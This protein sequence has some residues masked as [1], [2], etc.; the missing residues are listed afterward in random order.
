[1]IKYLRLIS[2]LHLEFLRVPLEETAVTV[3]PADPR[4]AESVL[5]LAGDISSIPS[6]VIDFIKLVEARFAKVIYVPGNH[7][8]YGHEVHEWSDHMNAMVAQHLSRTSIA[9]L[10]VARLELDGVRY[11]FG[12]LWADGGHSLQEQAEVGRSLRDFYVIKDGDFRFTVQD[13]V[14]LH[15]RQKAQ[16]EAYLKEPFDGKTVVISH[17]LPSYRLCHPRFGTQIN[18]GFASN[19]EDILAYDHAP[20]IWCHGHTHD[21]LDTKLWKTRIVCNPR[22]YP[23]EYSSA[24]NT[25]NTGPVFVELT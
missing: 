9:T 3:L 10:D 2:D 12:T 13:M 6:Q 17:H 14:T 1:M 16:L 20:D 4:D 23:G 15:K 7:E 24:F 21:S 11:L 8:F 18:G 25:F 19:C 5:V 22:G